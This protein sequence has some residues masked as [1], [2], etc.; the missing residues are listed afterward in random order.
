MRHREMEMC[1]IPTQAD[2]PVPGRRVNQLRYGALSGREEGAICGIARLGAL[3]DPIWNGFRQWAR[4]K[5]RKE[6]T[7]EGSSHDAAWG[8]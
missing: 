5:P 2:G 7:D 8:S 3:R 6:W 4:L 1:D